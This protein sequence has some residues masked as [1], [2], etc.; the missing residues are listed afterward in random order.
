MK[1]TLLFTAEENRV[2][3]RKYEANSI[4]FITGGNNCPDFR[5]YVDDEFVFSVS[6]NHFISFEYE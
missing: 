3:Q 5:I 2:R 6:P 1:A 4:R